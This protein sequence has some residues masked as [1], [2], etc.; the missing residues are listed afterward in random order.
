M[1][2]GDARVFKGFGGPDWNYRFIAALMF[3]PM[4]PH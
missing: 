3:E 4:P 2:G 1:V